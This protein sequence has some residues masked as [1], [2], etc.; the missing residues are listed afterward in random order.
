MKIV[1]FSFC[2]KIISSFGINIIYIRVMTGYAKN[3]RKLLAQIFQTR[4][5]TYSHL[6]SNC[7]NC[8]HFLF[9]LATI[10]IANAPN[11]KM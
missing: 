5:H 7:N 4:K 10:Q 6:S 2:C 1:V 11:L 9:P 3:H 8:A